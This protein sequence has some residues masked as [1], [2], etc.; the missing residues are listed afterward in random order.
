MAK[1]DVLSKN[2]GGDSASYSLSVDSGSKV[3]FMQTVSPV[4]W[5]KDTTHNDKALR[6]VSGTAS[7]GG[8]DSFSTTF[9]AGK[10]TASHTL[11]T[12]QIASHAHTVPQARIRNSNQGSTYGYETTASNLSPI[13]TGSTG[14]SG[15]HSHNLSLDIAYVDT[16]IATKD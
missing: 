1:L 10:T 5:T 16:I 12:P 11:S 3:T 9:G 4:G 15:A 8:I 13:N 2:S 7:N 6:V 14:G